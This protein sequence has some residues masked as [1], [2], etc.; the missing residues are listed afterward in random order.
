MSYLFHKTHEQAYVAH[1][2]GYSMCIGPYANDIDCRRPVFSGTSNGSSI[3]SSI[4]ICFSSELFAL[5][6]LYL[7]R[8]QCNIHVWK[9]YKEYL[10]IGLA[11]KST[12]IE[13]IFIEARL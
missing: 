12:N 7:I 1:V 6:F 8:N 11:I 10:E 2:I 9:D 4:F 3:K 5:F 13:S